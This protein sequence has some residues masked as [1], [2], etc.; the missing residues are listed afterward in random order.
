[1]SLKNKIIFFGGIHGVGKSTIC[2]KLCLEL[3]GG[4]LSASELINWKGLNSDDPSA[5]KVL[6]IQ[7]TQQRLIKSLSSL[8]SSDKLF[9]LDGHL[10]LLN[11]KGLPERIPASTIETIAPIMICVITDDPE[12]ISERLSSR[13]NK[14]YKA[15]D[16]E[17]FQNL[18]VEYARELS[19][20][21]NI[22]LSISNISDQ[23]DLENKIRQA[24]DKPE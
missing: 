5:K 11:S 16:L 2:K 22:P 17:I 14:E 9:L 8:T 3:G 15:A 4:Y 12:K 21:L 7:E 19:N 10:S 24:L 13:D 20:N 1:M 18:E 23:S 6:N